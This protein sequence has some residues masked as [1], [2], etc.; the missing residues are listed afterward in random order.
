MLHDLLP[1]TLEGALVVLGGWLGLIWSATLQSVAPLVWW[2]A[3]FVM[4]DIVTGIWAGIK[5]SGFSSSTLSA[6][7]LKRGLLS[8]SSSWHTALM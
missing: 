3:I 1:K 2:F 8:A 7:L 4:T 5:T 6:G